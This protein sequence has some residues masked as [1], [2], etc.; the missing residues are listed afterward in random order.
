MA[1]LSSACVLRSP[2]VAAPTLYV[3]ASPPEAEGRGRRESIGFRKTNCRD[4]CRRLTKYFLHHCSC[5]SY[6]KT[7][8]V[9]APCR[10]HSIKKGRSE[11]H[12]TEIQSQSNI[13]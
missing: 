11:E 9:S 8:L 12:T 2:P 6:G 7:K 10:A 5:R 1:L 13:L 4:S 3:P